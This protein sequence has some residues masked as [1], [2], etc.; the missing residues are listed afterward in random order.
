VKFINNS[1]RDDNLSCTS[2]PQ[3]WHIPAV[4][5]EY[6]RGEKLLSLFPPKSS[7]ARTVTVTPIALNDV[8]DSIQLIK[9]PLARIGKYDNMSPLDRHCCE[10]AS[11]VMDEMIST[12]EINKISALLTKLLSKQEKQFNFY[13]PNNILK[14][15]DVSFYNHLS[16]PHK[17]YYDK[18]VR[19]S[20]NEVI[21]KICAGTVLQANCAAWHEQRRRPLTSTA[22][23]TFNTRKEGDYDEESVRILD[24]SFDGNDATR[25]GQKM[26]P[27]AKAQYARTN[28]VDLIDTGLV[29][30]DNENWLCASPEAIFR[31]G[32][33]FILDQCYMKGIFKVLWPVCS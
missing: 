11:R 29:I 4:K 26:E 16:P 31:C 10:G 19:C 8:Q 18:H 7:H 21:I 27:I 3:N 24:K 32:D 5:D 1:E 15:K 33:R 23:H 6:S 20:R 12:L 17:H 13:V 9:C 14:I 25:H 22:C 2:K 28:Q 30:S